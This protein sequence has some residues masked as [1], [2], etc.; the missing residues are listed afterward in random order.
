M[1]KPGEY[2]FLKSPAYFPFMYKET[3]NKDRFIVKAL[4][5]I[6]ADRGIEFSSLSHDWILQL[7]YKGLTHSI[8]GFYFDLNPAAAA[9][10]ANDKSALASILDQRKIPHVEHVL[11]LAPRLSNYLGSDGNWSRAIQYAESVGYPLVCKTNQGTRGDSV[12]KIENQTELEAAFQHIHTSAR[13]LAL[14]PFYSIDAEYRII[15][16]RN[17]VLLCYHKEQLY[18]TGNG[19]ST[20]FELIQ[21]FSREMIEAALEEPCFQ[22]EEVPAKG[23]KVPLVWKHNLSKGAIP[24]FNINKKTRQKIVKLAR[25]TCSAIGMQFAAVDVIETKGELRVIEV[26]SGICLEHLSQFSDEGRTLAF[27]VYASAVDSIFNLQDKG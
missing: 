14:S 5:Q 8:Y 24:Q 7:R 9:T 18:V 6:A 11:F 1:Q 25:E 16:L 21:S 19:H 17:D 12:F 23:L 4:S 22:L 3:A 26:N 15:L 10:I 20:F 2:W 27:N 13:G